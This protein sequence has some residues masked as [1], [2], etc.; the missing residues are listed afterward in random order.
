MSILGIINTFCMSTEVPKWSQFLWEFLYCSQH[1]FAFD[2]YAQNI[3]Y[4]YCNHSHHI[5]VVVRRH[6][7]R[8]WHYVQC[9]AYI[10]QIVRWKWKYLEVYII[11]WN[12]FENGRTFRSRT[13]GSRTIGSR[14]IGSLD[15]SFPGQ[16]VPC[17]IGS[18]DNWFPYFI[19]KKVLNNFI[20]CVT[21]ATKAYP[22]ERE[23]LQEKV[24]IRSLKEVSTI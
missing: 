14:T 7:F 23:H 1:S 12:V 24:I 19:K 4:S 5:G 2:I 17:T 8:D 22:S 16:L 13:T 20:R 3:T 11:T 10:Y 21:F 15:Y 18:P 6:N 9:K